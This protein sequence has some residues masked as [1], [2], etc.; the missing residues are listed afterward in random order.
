MPVCSLRESGR[1]LDH[2]SS[3][4]RHRWDE[5]SHTGMRWILSLDSAAIIPPALAAVYLLLPFKCSGP[6]LRQPRQ[7]QS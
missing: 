2:H 4:R 3:D 7:N 6:T 1:R 5:R